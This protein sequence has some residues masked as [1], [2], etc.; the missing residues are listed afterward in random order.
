M[1][2]TSSQ[3]RRKYSFFLR[4][5]ADFDFKIDYNNSQVSFYREFSETMI[6]ENIKIS[7]GEE[8]IFNGAS[9]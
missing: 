7:R 2:F 8:N 3:W 9:F 5:L 4:E 1:V 6:E